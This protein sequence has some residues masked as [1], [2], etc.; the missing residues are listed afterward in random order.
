MICREIVE[1]IRTRRQ[2]ARI[3]QNATIRK[4]GTALPSHE[5]LRPDIVVYSNDKIEIIEISCPYDSVI[6]NNANTNDNNNR[7]KLDITYSNKRS[8]YEPL[9][10]ACEHHFGIKTS[11]YIIAISSLGAILSQSQSDLASVLATPRTS[12]ECKRIMRRLSTAAILG[13]YLTF[14][15]IGRRDNGNIL[16]TSDATGNVDMEEPDLPHQE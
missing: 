10:A 6:Q 5:N 8:K 11:L 13:S 7:T 4:D 9:R 1:A 2:G 15:K 16:L 12:K 3:S 14:Y